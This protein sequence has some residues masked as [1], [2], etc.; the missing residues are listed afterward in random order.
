MSQQYTE[1]IAR[2][3]KAMSRLDAEA[4]V[5]LCEPDVEFRSRIADADDVTYRGHDGIRDYMANL[6][7]VFE[8]VQTEPLEVVEGSDR[9]V[10][11]NRFRARGRHS[12]AEVEDRFFQALRFRDDKVQWW[13]FYPS[14]AEALE[15]LGLS[16]QAMSQENVEIVKRSYEH[17]MATG[18]IRTGAADLVW[19]VSNLGWPDQQVYIGDEGGMQFLA[20][21]AAAWDDWEMEAEEYLDAGDSV[22]VILTQ[23]GRSQATGIP[24]E[25][26]FAQVWTLSNGQGIRMQLYGSVEE[27]LEAVGL[28]E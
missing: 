20:E 17:Y 16:E 8:W 3:Y 4:M 18:E 26:R 27:A 28:S 1:N 12:G 10:V 14:K 15:A 23:R 22:V 7:E 5:A 2:A 11:C 25:M 24:V 19:D 21:W 9:A 6:A 13:A